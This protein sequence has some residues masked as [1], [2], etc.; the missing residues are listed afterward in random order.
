MISDD[1]AIA[2]FGPLEIDESLPVHSRERLRKQR[3]FLRGFA[4]SG[5]VL[6]GLLAAKIARDTEHKWRRDDE[7]YAKQFR[8]AEQHAADIVERE[9]IRRAVHGYDEPVLFQGQPTIVT[10]P[11]TGKEK[12]YTIKKYSDSLMALVLKGRRREV[13][14]DK[15]EQTHEVKKGGVLIVPGQVLD[16]DAWEKAAAE[17]QAQYVKGSEEQ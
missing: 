1:E 3:L 14:G 17:Q 9:A 8:I 6:D 13:Y 2:L 11:E 7:V 10:D 15:I 5:V 4:A 12:P 16:Q